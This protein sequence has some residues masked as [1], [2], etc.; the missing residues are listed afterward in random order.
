MAAPTVV[1]TDVTPSV[2]PEVVDVVTIVFSEAVTGLVRSNF[3]LTLDGVS[4]GLTALQTVSTVNNI[5]WL[6]KGLAAVTHRKGDYILTLLTTPTITAIAAPAGR[7][8]AVGDYTSWRMQVAPWDPTTDC[9]RSAHISHHSMFPTTNGGSMVSIPLKTSG[10]VTNDGGQ[11][12]V[13]IFD[14]QFIAD[15]VYQNGDWVEI[16]GVTGGAATVNKLW[17]VEDV[18]INSFRLKDSMYSAP[19]GNGGSATRWHVRRWDAISS[20]TVSSAA[21]RGN[22]FSYTLP[23]WDDNRKVSYNEIS[24]IKMVT[25]AVEGSSGRVRLTATAHNFSIGSVVEVAGVRV[26]ETKDEIGRGTWVVASAN[27]SA[28]QIELEGSVYP[29]GLTYWSQSGIVRLATDAETNRQSLVTGGTSNGS[30]LTPIDT[31][32]TA[33]NLPRGYAQS[34]NDCRA[35]MEAHSAVKSGYYFSGSCVGTLH[36]I[37]ERGVNAGYPS[38]LTPLDKDFTNGWAIASSSTN[39]GKLALT[40]AGPKVPPAAWAGKVRV[41]IFGHSNPTYCL[42]QYIDR[43][44]AMNG[45]RRL[46]GVTGLVTSSLNTHTITDNVI[47]PPDNVFPSWLVGEQLYLTKAGDPND[48]RYRTIKSVSGNTI[49]TTSDFNDAITSGTTYRAGAMNY[50]V[51]AVSGSTITLR[52]PFRAA[53]GTG[54]ALM[55]MG[56]LASGTSI[57]QGGAKPGGGNY[58]RVTTEVAHGLAIGNYVVIFDASPGAYNCA[59][60]SSPSVSL[61]VS[62]HKVVF[63]GSAPADN[64]FDIDKTYVG[65]A[66]GG[67]WYGTCLVLMPDGITFGAEQTDVGRCDTPDCRHGDVRTLYFTKQKTLINDAMARHGARHISFLDEHAFRHYQSTAFPVIT[68]TALDGS[69]TEET[70]NRVGDLA[71]WLA[72]EWSR[73]LTANV[74]CPLTRDTFSVSQRN[75]L[76]SKWGG[77]MSEGACNVVDRSLWQMGPSGFLDHLDAIL[78]AGKR[79]YYV[80]RDGDA[81]GSAQFSASAVVGKNLQL[82][83][84]GDSGLLPNVTESGGTHNRAGDVIGIYG[85]P[86]ASINGIHRV[87][88]RASGNVVTLETRGVSHT[89]GGGTIVFSRFSPPFKVVSLSRATD[90]STLVKTEFPHNLPDALDD[91]TQVRF[92][93]Y[94]VSGHPVAGTL[95]DAVRT[96]ADE[97]VLP[98]RPWVSDSTTPAICFFDRADTNY[99]LGLCYMLWKPDRALQYHSGSLSLS[100]NTRRAY[101]PTDLT[102]DTTYSIKSFDGPPTGTHPSQPKLTMVRTG[103]GFTEAVLGEQLM[104]YDGTNMGEW[105]RIVSYT[106]DTVTVDA[107]FGFNIDTGHK[108]VI[109]RID[110]NYPAKVLQVSRLFNSGT[111]SVEVYPQKS[112]VKYINMP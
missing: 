85:H 19:N 11:Y 100:V 70:I 57:T 80:P 75:L 101:I 71:A 40:I 31:P 56:N 18:Q 10:S 58:A 102:Y 17:E 29:S 54:G 44:D 62:V 30:A 51:D 63:V 103:A 13:T 27:F 26:Q 42:D 4:V 6:L 79:Y 3:T 87:R 72:T 91:L 92:Y 15:Q 95:Y 50:V 99:F 90:G 68:N 109:G 24:P 98:L 43:V 14:A 97:F 20:F 2:G 48:G 46:Y 39:G 38:A 64:V 76:I 61:G 49:T 53:N 69:T 55:V 110:F 28:N 94:T 23:A 33:Y 112:M 45:L 67:R 81:I 106:A 111:R 36:E 93:G 8:L 1:I 35:F 108:F 25:G 96:S 107:A 32:A 47:F 41:V 66:S 12:R 77:L 89:S 34:F 86:V 37:L 88:S 73:Q 22:Q 84:T 78:D 83:T 7:T 105:R 21:K 52:T 5:T 104:C 82:T 74:S 9:F 60:A 65:N 59:R 16:R